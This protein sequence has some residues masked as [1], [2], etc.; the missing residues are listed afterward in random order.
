MENTNGCTKRNDNSRNEVHIME[1]NQNEVHIGAHISGVIKTYFWGSLQKPME[2]VAAQTKM[3]RLRLQV[4]NPVWSIP[5]QGPMWSWLPLFWD[6]FGLP[7]QKP[8]LGGPHILPINSDAQ[9]AWEKRASLLGWLVELNGE[10]LSNKRKSGAAGQLK[11]SRTDR[12]QEFRIF[13]Q[14]FER[15]APAGTK[16]VGWPNICSSLSTCSWARHA[17]IWKRLLRT[18]ENGTKRVRVEI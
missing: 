16:T 2:K 15:S 1:T 8:L 9:W 17:T 13:L 18:E 11:Y 12:A 10:T 4:V 7:P 14:P 5:Q 6:L 3:D